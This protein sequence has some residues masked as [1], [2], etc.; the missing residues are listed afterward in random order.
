MFQDLPPDPAPIVVTVPAPE[1]SQATAAD[2]RV[3]AALTDAQINGTITL[4]RP[5]THIFP[6]DESY[7]SSAML[8]GNLRS[9]VSTLFDQV[10]WTNVWSDT[11]I[12]ADTA[13]TYDQINNP[14]ECS[15]DVPPEGRGS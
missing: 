8:I 7:V 14:I 1:R 6:A 4:G 11:R 10:S 13:A 9:R 15:N 5:L 3:A 2:V 12:G